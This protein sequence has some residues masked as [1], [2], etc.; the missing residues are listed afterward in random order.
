MYC[1]CF[2]LFFGL[3]ESLLSLSVPSCCTITSSCSPSLSNDETTMYARSLPDNDAKI[4]TH[5]CLC[6]LNNNNMPLQSP[7]HALTTTLFMITTWP[8]H[9]P[10]P[11]PLFDNDDDVCLH[12]LSSWWW[13]ENDN[14]PSPS[15][16]LLHEL[17]NLYQGPGDYLLWGRYSQRDAM[18]SKQG[19]GW[20]QETR[21]LCHNQ[22]SCGFVKLMLWLHRTRIE[23]EIQARWV[24]KYYRLPK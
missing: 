22:T 8:C 2:S 12:S 5:P 21:G 3:H 1:C 11:H 7:S 9:H 14:E 24:F 18:S 10:Q 16:S 17:I 15:H 13:C 4:T 23:K 19:W 20:E 6:P